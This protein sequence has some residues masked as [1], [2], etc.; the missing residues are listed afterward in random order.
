MTEVVKG[1]FLPLI[2]ALH[3]R[4]FVPW[5]DADRHQSRDVKHWLLSFI[6]EHASFLDAER[7]VFAMKPIPQGRLDVSEAAWH[8]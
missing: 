4:H 1:V 2:A 8:S 7:Y 5:N 3:A 6:A